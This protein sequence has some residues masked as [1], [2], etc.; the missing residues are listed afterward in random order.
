MRGTKR[1]TLT[2]DELM[3]LQEEPARKKFKPPIAFTDNS[4]GE[5]S[6]D[7]SAGTSHSGSEER[8]TGNEEV[9]EECG[10]TEGEDNSDAEGG[11][12]E[13]EE[14]LDVSLPLW[15]DSDS[16]FNSSR[17][18]IVPRATKPTPPALTR[19]AQTQPASFEALGISSAL[20]NALAKMSIKAPTEIQAVCIP[21]LLAGEWHTSLSLDAY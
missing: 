13:S 20:L 7:E 4:E 19:P 10:S 14:E 16:R 15:D 3:R 1:H 5:E 8:A 17:I 9:E 18:A 12:A 2:T 11:G 21:P 6:E